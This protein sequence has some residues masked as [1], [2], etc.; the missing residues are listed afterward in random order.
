MLLA[1][2]RGVLHLIAASS[3]ATHH[4]E[5]FQLQRDEGPC[6]DCFHSGA[7]VIVPDLEAE[8][9]RWPDFARVADTVEVLILALL[10]PLGI[11]T[12]GLV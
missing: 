3:E 6:L 1:D 4:L 10:L 7:P 11:A 8:S 9:Q 2:G 12:A 5:V